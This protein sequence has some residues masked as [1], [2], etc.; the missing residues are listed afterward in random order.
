MQAL[1]Q[2]EESQRANLFLLPN[3]LRSE[4]DRA[5][6][7]SSRAAQPPARVALSLGAEVLQI[8]VSLVAASVDHVQPQTAVPIWC[9]SGGDTL[10][11]D[12]RRVSL[13]P[14]SHTL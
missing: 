14:L 12:G 10:E 4:T 7:F 9:F 5:T 13:Y 6:E 8:A 2:A 11:E 1:P 3:G